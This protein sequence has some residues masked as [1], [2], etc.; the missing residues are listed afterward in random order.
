MAYTVFLEWGDRSASAS[1]TGGRK[2]TRR[3][4]VQTDDPAMLSEVAAINACTS[5][6]GLYIGSACPSWT[7]AKCTDISS[8]PH[9]EDPTIWYVD[10]TFLEPKPAPG[11]IYGVPPGNPNNNQGGSSGSPPEKDQQQPIVTISYREVEVFQ[12]ADLDGNQYYNTAGDQLENAPPNIVI[13]T[14]YRYKYYRQTYSRSYAKA[15]NGAVNSLPYETHDEYTLRALVEGARPVTIDYFTGWELDMMV[16]SNPLG[17]YPTKILDAGRARNVPQNLVTFPIVYEK[18]ADVDKNGSL[19]NKIFL[20]NGINGQESSS[21]P[22][23]LPFRRHNLI[24]FNQM[25]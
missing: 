7:P 3:Y 21:G 15:I 13:H 14:I 22:K 9:S 25:L 11:T 5:A 2:I 12:G 10:Y 1:V 4:G 8:V 23:Y 20:L 18:K 6:S 24:D 16:E 19:T 17:W